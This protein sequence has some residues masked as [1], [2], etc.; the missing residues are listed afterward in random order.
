MV[1]IIWLCFFI[2]FMFLVYDG[3]WHLIAIVCQITRAAI[4][5]SFSAKCALALPWHVIAIMKFRLL[6]CL[7]IHCKKISTWIKGKLTKVF[8]LGPSNVP[9]RWKICSFATE[10]FLLKNLNNYLFSHLHQEMD[11]IQFWSF[12]NVWQIQTLFYN[13][14]N[15]KAKVKKFEP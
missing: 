4:W 10:T 11:W 5:L 8:L 15:S 3:V 9:S 13:Q 14:L 1:K 6:L 7:Y 12:R 2:C